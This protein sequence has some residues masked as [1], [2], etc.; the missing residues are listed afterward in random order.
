MYLLCSL[1]W[2]DLLPELTGTDPRRRRE[3]ASNLVRGAGPENVIDE[4]VRGLLADADP[5]LRCT[6][7]AVVDRLG[8]THLHPDVRRLEDDGNGWVRHDARACLDEE[9]GAARADLDATLAARGQQWQSE[10]AA[11]PGPDY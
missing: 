2:N 9:F 6:G 1:T 10:T 8:L 5:V 4:V 7:I 11:V 3:A